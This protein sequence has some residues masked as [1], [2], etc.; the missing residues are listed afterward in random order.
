[1]T[2]S[3]TNSIM[4][5]I[6]RNCD[7]R[8]IIDRMLDIPTHNAILQGCQ[9]YHKNDIDKY[10]K[11]T[12]KTLKNKKKI[13][14]KHWNYHISPPDEIWELHK[15]SKKTLSNLE[16]LKNS[17]YVWEN[18]ANIWVIEQFNYGK[19]KY[20]NDIMVRGYHPVLGKVQYWRH[21][22]R[23]MGAGQTKIISYQNNKKKSQQV[24][25]IT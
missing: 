14:K 17:H 8:S 12:I 13:C 10:I 18:T 2:N 20:A 23:S 15:L 11:Y 5:S 21:E 22:T 24:S 4:N 19:I 16:R 1:M 3:F 25:K 6:I 7:I 9:L